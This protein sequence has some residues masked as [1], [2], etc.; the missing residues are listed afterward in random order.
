MW[1]GEK[2][3]L[4]NL[5]EII[6][7]ERD[8]KRKHSYILIRKVEKVKMK[9]CCL[10]SSNITGLVSIYSKVRASSVEDR[11]K[12]RSKRETS[13]SKTVGPPPKEEDKNDIG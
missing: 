7:T 2:T 10:E 9:M 13:E 4:G 12:E 3:N 5:K 8:K 11:E 6:R 1:E